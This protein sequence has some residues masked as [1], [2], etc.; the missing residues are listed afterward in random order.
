MLA[1]VALVCGA[2]GA[3]ARQ[4]PSRAASAHLYWTNNAAGT[5]VEASLNG[6]G[7]K[8]IATGQKSKPG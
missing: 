1:A 2:G 5:I 3:A 6:Q 4:G 7:A 8:I